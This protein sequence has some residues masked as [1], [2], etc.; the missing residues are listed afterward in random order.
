MRS[1]PLPHIEEMKRLIAEVRRLRQQVA[2]LVQ[3]MRGERTA[4]RSETDNS[5]QVIELKP[6]DG[7]TKRRP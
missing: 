2:D 6:Q 7:P 5:P 3:R 4:Y 1:E